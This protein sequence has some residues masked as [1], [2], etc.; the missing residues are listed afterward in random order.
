MWKKLGLVGPGEKKNT[1]IFHLTY[2]SDETPSTCA[3]LPS[4]DKTAIRSESL[5]HLIEWSS[6][7]F[8]ISTGHVNVT[9]CPRMTGLVS[10]TLDRSK[11]NR[12]KINQFC[13]KLNLTS[14]KKIVF[15]SK[16]DY[17]RKL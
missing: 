9:G 12:K 14:R 7:Q 10:S 17:D 1:H 11:K 4:P 3:N 15:R 2:L 6:P 8:S 16:F 5:N 13:A